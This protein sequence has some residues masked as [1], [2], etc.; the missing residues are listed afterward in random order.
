MIARLFASNRRFLVPEVVQTSAMDC[1]PAALK[2]IL[3]GFGISASYGRLREACQTDVDGTSIDTMEDVAIQLGLDAEQVMVPTD[4]LL[5]SESQSLPAIVVV[6]LPNGLTHFVVVWDVVGAF[7]QV[8]DP[9]TGRRWPT[10]QQFLQELYIHTHPID[11]DTWLAW[12][13]SEG[14][15]DPLRQRMLAMGT[16]ESQPAQ[17]QLLQNALDANHWHAL[18]CLDAATR[19]VEAL[20]QA[21]GLARGTETFRVLNRFYQR[22]RSEPPGQSTTIPPLYWCVHPASDDTDDDTDRDS[23]TLLMQGAVLVRFLGPRQPDTITDSEP[24]QIADL[25]EPGDDAEQAEQPDQD[26]DEAPGDTTPT[27][28]LS[29]ELVAAL[30]EPAGKPGIEILR[31]L[32]ADGLLTPSILLM[33]L[34]FSALGVLVQAWLLLGLLELT[35]S[36]TI[37]GQ[38]I[39]AMGFFFAFLVAFLL[40]RIPITSTTFRIGRRL[41]TRLRIKFLEKLPRLG[42]RY[43]QSRL[44]SDMTQRAHDLRQLRHLPVIGIQFISLFFQIILTAIGIIVLDPLS[45][46]LTF[47]ATLFAIGITFLTQP[48]LI[49]RDLRM[50]THLSALSRFYLDALLGLVPIR[51]HGAEQSVRREHEHLL[52]EW[53][54]ASKDFYRVELVER[55]VEL[56]VGLVFSVWI[57]FHYISHGGE[58]SG[59]LLLFYWTLSLPALGRALAAIVQQY[60]THRNRTLR[61]LEPLNAPEDS[62]ATAGKA[63]AGEA[64]AGTAQAASVTLDTVTVYAGGHPILTNLNLEVQP[65]EHIA[66]IGPS[67]AGKSSLVGLLLG[68]HRPSSGRVLVDGHPLH[69]EHLHTTR[70]ATA[71]VD[72]A[73]QLWNRSLL[74]NLRYGSGSTGNSMGTLPI[75]QANLF[76]VLEKFPNGLQTVL[77]EGGGLVSG[78]EGQRVRLG[79]ALFRP[80]TRLVI[81][82]EP[83]RGLDRAQRQ[84]LLAR[85]REQWR[86]ATLFFISHDVGESQ[87]FDRVLVIEQG[88]I[89][90]DDSPQVLAALPHSRYTALLRAEEA[91]RTG[92]WSGATWR[93]L[94]L[95]EGTLSEQPDE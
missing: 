73:V 37:V 63:T 88:H 18:A 44:I 1:G 55:G 46:P 48:V 30:N 33:S 59:V 61:L 70:R 47:L 29:P 49:E 53:I 72:P 17:E 5:L 54:R 69:G 40:L 89:V 19:M 24:G 16:D 4:Y 95:D 82:D 52:V 26:V 22:A 85:A 51:T 74:D 41:E 71:W 11:T 42:D 64:T 80:G 3:E 8:M 50:R 79:R 76:G 6:T 68:W 10:R 28:P 66:I 67:G 77:G 39:G 35:Q 87:T 27:T 86:D 21:R 58:T 91:V 90:E 94:W 13:A 25:T 20:I 9:S 57:V 2:A 31:M 84:T 93:R 15:C 7:V 34:A 12:A 38:R 81:L 56:I 32:R 45:A 83:F 75:E 60:P 36:L 62:E 14:F 78:G 92:M 23:D 65:G 43:F